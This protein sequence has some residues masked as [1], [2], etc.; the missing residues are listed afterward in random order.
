MTNPFKYTVLEYVKENLGGDWAI[1]EYFIRERPD[2]YMD[3]DLITILL[4]FVTMHEE[5]DGWQWEF[6]HQ[7]V[8]RLYSADWFVSALFNNTFSPYRMPDILLLTQDSNDKWIALKRK[9]SAKIDMY[10]VLVHLSDD[11]VDDSEA[12]QCIDD[13]ITYFREQKKKAQK[14]SPDEHMA[15][16]KWID[17]YTDG[18]PNDEQKKK[19]QKK[20]KKSHGKSKQKKKKKKK[21]KSKK[22][23]N[24]NV[25]LSRSSDEEYK[26]PAAAKTKSKTSKKRPYNFK[27]EVNNKWPIKKQQKYT[28]PNLL[29]YDGYDIMATMNLTTKKQQQILRTLA[30]TAIQCTD[31]IQQQLTN[32]DPWV[33]IPNIK[34]PAEAT[35]KKPQYSQYKM[36]RHLRSNLIR[37]NRMIKRQRRYVDAINEWFVNNPQESF[38]A[39]T[40]ADLNAKAV[41]ADDWAMSNEVDDVQ[42][43]SS[44]TV[45]AATSSNS[46][47]SSEMPNESVVVPSSAKSGDS[48]DRSAKK[49]SPSDSDDDSHGGH[50][51]KDVRISNSD[52]VS[53]DNSIENQQK[54]KKATLAETIENLNIVSTEQK[55]SDQ[56]SNVIEENSTDLQMFDVLFF[57]TIGEDAAAMEQIETRLSKKLFVALGE[58]D[59]YMIGQL[60]NEKK[61]VL[62]DVLNILQKGSLNELFEQEAYI[63]IV[64]LFGE[65][66]MDRLKNL[67]KGE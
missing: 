38:E 4:D 13:P 33:S 55:S 60:S 36:P 5:G 2:W 58:Q 23:K 11:K 12:K 31:Y 67:M 17:A 9:K 62:N 10:H 7:E 22:K 63:E 37:Q 30:D 50:R 27:S 52:T 51:R 56:Q 40:A 61:N 57:F 18:P 65:N 19:K 1:M 14:M 6:Q 46:A 53:S 3:E 20:R 28:D 43:G 21:H 45:V 32:Y 48:V 59:R 66:V 26:P 15:R 25:D 24:K 42:N 39:V 16:C 44:H 49:S 35:P 41:K 64:K 54:S 8:G 47:V 29:S 34:Q